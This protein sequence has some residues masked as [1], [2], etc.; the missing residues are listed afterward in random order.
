MVAFRE[1]HPVPT[2]FRPEFF[3][4]ISFVKHEVEEL[5]IADELLTDP[6]VLNL[7]LMS[8]KFVVP[9][10]VCYIFIASIS[11]ACMYSSNLHVGS[12]NAYKLISYPLRIFEGPL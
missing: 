7:S 4:V 6:E 9:P 2:F 8:T 5:S 10:I 1:A 12:W 11:K 3:T